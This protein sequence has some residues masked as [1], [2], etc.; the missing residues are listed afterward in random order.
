MIWLANGT[1]SVT[2]SA[3]NFY[4]F[5]WLLPCAPVFAF[6]FVCYGHIVNLSLFGQEKLE[7]G[8]HADFFCRME[9]GCAPVLIKQKA[10]LSLWCHRKYPVKIGSGEEN[11]LNWQHW[12][13]MLSMIVLGL[14]V[15]IAT[16]FVVL[17]THGVSYAALRLS[18]PWHSLGKNHGWPLLIV[19]QMKPWSCS[20]IRLMASANSATV[21]FKQNYVCVI[22]AVPVLFYAQSCLL[23]KTYG[24]GSKAIIV[25]RM[26]YGCV[27]SIS[28]QSRTVNLEL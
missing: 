21:I 3:V 16:N 6:A 9:A 14:P 7:W 20:R 28:G 11:A 13:P 10:L 1:L 17:N 15:T 24:C 12:L 18:L 4:I 25:T 27:Q 22:V 2:P 8:D 19:P 23:C 26:T 5:L